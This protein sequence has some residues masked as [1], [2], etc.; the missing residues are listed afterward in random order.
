MALYR[1][2]I[3]LGLA[4]CTI[5]LVEIAPS[6]RHPRLAYAD[7]PVLH[8]WPAVFA[9]L[10]VRTVSASIC[11]G[12][13]SFHPSKLVLGI[14]LPDRIIHHFHPMLSG[15]SSPQPPYRDADNDRGVGG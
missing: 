1:V 11:A 6:Q 13:C 9:T 4:L 2:A 8:R 14:D 7:D 5:H 3:R 10:A 12:E 15:L